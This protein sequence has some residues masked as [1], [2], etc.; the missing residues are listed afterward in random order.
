[1]TATF[2]NSEFNFNIGGGGV[3]DPTGNWFQGQIDEVA[4]WWRA[5]STNELATLMAT[6]AEQV[7]YTPLINTD[8]RSQMYG[9][10]GSAYVRLPFNVADP[11]AFDSL[12]LLVRF[13]DGFAAYLNG[14]L[15]AASNA[16][17]A[18]AW[19]ATATQR[20]L[21]RDA[22]QWTEFDVSAAR[23]YLQAGTNILA[24]QGLNVAAT[25]TDFLLQAQLVGNSV[26]DYG[27]A[28]R[29][30]SQPTPGGPNG[31]SPADWGPIFSGAG[32]QP[33]AL[34]PPARSWS[35]PW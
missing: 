1:M 28:W 15:V 21:D 22:V 8:V 33:A 24:I 25:N 18:L 32:H 6:N 11:A 9:V 16:P 20:H 4:V 27:T 35:P 31:T 7:S 19:N 34:R 13:D 23:A 17:A 26:V 5:L 29:Y 14:H 30:F 2:G 12:Q 10:T 3:Y